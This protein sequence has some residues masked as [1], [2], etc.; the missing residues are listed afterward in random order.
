MPQEPSQ[1]LL[2]AIEN[3]VTTDDRDRHN[4][5]QSKGRQAPI[6]QKLY[7]QAQADSI[8]EGLMS[9][10]A[11]NPNLL[12]DSNLNRRIQNVM[13]NRIFLKLVENTDVFQEMSN[14]SES[15]E[16]SRRQLDAFHDELDLIQMPTK[17]EVP[18][19]PLQNQTINDKTK[20]SS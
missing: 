9:R 13:D 2:K 10:I 5:K 12:N 8:M 11:N 19:L 14:Q 18:I 7:S 4:E 16:D 17:K 20:K 6:S 15:Q 3:I 1:Q